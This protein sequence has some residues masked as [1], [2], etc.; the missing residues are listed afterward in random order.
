ME[1]PGCRPSFP[2][3][4]VTRNRPKLGSTSRQQLV[5]GTDCCCGAPVYQ[6]EFTATGPHPRTVSPAIIIRPVPI[7]CP[8]LRTAQS[9]CAS[10]EF[11]PERRA[12]SYPPDTRSLHYGF[13]NRPK[14]TNAIDRMV[15]VTLGTVVRRTAGFVG[16]LRWW[17]TGA[18]Q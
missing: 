9:R 8:G 13:E 7:R 4:S 16:K 18:W 1:F 12:G 2:P 15:L 6:Q 17:W 11:A 10:V 14:G 3:D 5:P